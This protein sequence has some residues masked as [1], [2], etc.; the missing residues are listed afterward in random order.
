MSARSR[1]LL[2]FGIGASVAIVPVLLGVLVVVAWLRPQEMLA[3]PAQNVERHISVRQVAALKT[4]EPAIVRRDTISSSAPTAQALLEAVPECSKEWDGRRGWL[5][6]VRRRLGQISDSPMSGAERIVVE[7]AQLDDALARFS[8]RANRRVSD[9][10]GFDAQRW[11]D[12]VRTALRA[13]VE[14][15]GYPNRRFVVQCSDI[16]SAVAALTRDDGR[17]LD[18][19]A[20]RGTEVQRVVARWRA[21]QFVEIS[22]REVARANPWS[23]V[24]GCVYMG[25]AGD[26]HFSPAYFV[27]EAH[28]I[29]ERICTQAAM[30][31][32]MR[33]DAHGAVPQAIIGEPTPDLL[34]NDPRWSVPPSLDVML[35]SLATLRRP[36]GALYRFYT[37]RPSQDDASVGPLTLALDRVVAGADAVVASVNAARATA[38]SAVD[39]RPQSQAAPGG[40]RSNAS[41]NVAD[42]DESG[43]GFGPNRIMAGGASIDVGFSVDITIDPALQALA[44]RT[45]ACYT[46]RQDVC[47]AAGIHRK[48]DEGKAIGHRL[49]EHAM[50]RMAAVAIIDVPTGRIEALASALSPCT[51]QEYDGPGRD[52]SCDKRLPYPIRYRPDALLNAAVFHDA[53]PASVIKPIMATAFLTDREVGARWL[54]SERAQW[55][56]TPWPTRD[57]LRGEL[58]RSDSARFLDRMFCADKAFANCARPWN[59]QATAA[60]FGWN[61]DCVAPRDD[62]GKRDLLFGRVVGD[63]AEYVPALATVVPYGRL[64]VEPSGSEIGA[65]FRIRPAVALDPVKVSA[66]AAGADGR[67]G[68]S[69]DWE[70][71]RGVIVVDAVAEGWG[72][73][74]ARSSALGV[75]GMLASLAA[76]ANGEQARE[77]HLVEAIRGVGRADTTSR[78]LALP[79][80]TRDT[81][82]PRIPHDAAELI[83]NALSYSHRGGTARLACEQVFDPR[84]CRDF[85]W[86]AGKTG[87]PTFPN[88]DVSLDELARLCVPGAPRSRSIAA[89]CGALRPYKWYVAAYR[90]DASSPRWTKVVGVLTERNWMADTGRIHG[91]GDRG[92]NPAAEIA[93]QIASRHAGRLAGAK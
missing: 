15:P 68:S 78:A 86:I 73:G 21:D 48:E 67:R 25:R 24:A 80:V 44:Q 63:G 49:L 74:N 82:A 62:C 4:F 3:K 6:S 29:G 51:R 9:G 76:A 43:V 66:C 58:M 46:G 37:E 90:T 28:G 64:L 40:A 71:C 52:P 47:E 69:D 83:L 20:W 85:D 70:K 12:A 5:S 30:R 61:A 53:M 11:F 57:S 10:V 92:P 77:P 32:A 84:A 72:Q 36:T 59:V 2:D 41:D 42:R 93:L 56:R 55:Q 81:A 39:T 35:R 23:G 27:S 14:A 89:S 13:P 1:T 33:D 17:M 87:T 26:A 22:P 50:V 60:L 79:A 54:A 88:D 16:A 18:A 65:S 91:A 34:P 7:L 45:A 75:A 8:M 31:G 19:L 38:Q